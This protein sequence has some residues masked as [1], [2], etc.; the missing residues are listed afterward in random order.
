MFRSWKESTNDCP[1]ETILALGVVDIDNCVTPVKPG[2]R[3]DVRATTER[4]KRHK[5]CRQ[6]LDEIQ[7][8][9]G[10]PTREAVHQ[11]VERGDYRFYIQR[12]ALSDDDGA[13]VKVRV[14][15]AN[16]FVII[17]EIA[18]AVLAA[19]HVKKFSVV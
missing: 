10:P 12:L 13:R 9:T 19:S 3:L 6:F 4:S 7:N 11:L 16:T 8:E 2:R 18:G 5:H 17:R 15:T 1:T 14:D